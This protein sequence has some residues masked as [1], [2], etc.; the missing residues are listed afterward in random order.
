MKH[1]V[2]TWSAWWRGKSATIQ[3]LPFYSSG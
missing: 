3:L 2:F 1:R